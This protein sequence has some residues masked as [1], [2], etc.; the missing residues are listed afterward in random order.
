MEAFLSHSKKDVNIVNSTFKM[1]QR[2]KIKP[3]I[4]EFE[5]IESG[6]LGAKEIREMID[7]SELFLLFLSEHVVN[8][9]D[10]AKTIHTQN[11]VNF[12]LGCAYAQKK[13][14]KKFIYVFEPFIKQLHFP[15]PYLDYYILFDPNRDQ[16]W[17]AI[18]EVLNQERE[19]EDVA[20]SLNPLLQM[21][22]VGFSLGE[23]LKG[24][25]L[26][27]PSERNGFPIHHEVC[28]A[29]YTLLTKPDQWLCPV[30]RKPTTWM[31]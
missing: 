6:K 9:Q 29:K 31:P 4:A 7:K 5:E 12:E 16:H 14:K 27:R 1:C 25:P 30:C 21:V 13:D 26:Q 28:G 18:K 8:E 10:Y 3:N 2:A 24:H 11:W 17:D 19:F 20:R 22:M 15:I 23:R